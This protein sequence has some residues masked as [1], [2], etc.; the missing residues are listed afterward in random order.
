MKLTKTILDSLV[1]D[2][3]KPRFVWDSEVPGFGVR[4][5]PTGKKSFVIGYRRNKTFHTITIGKYGVL[6]LHQGREAAKD[7]L[8]KIQ[9]GGDPL[10]ERQR[11]KNTTMAMLCDEYLSRHAHKKKSHRDDF[12]R[13]RSKIRPLFGKMLIED[14]TRADIIRLHDSLSSTPYE[15][16][17]TLSLLSKMFNLAIMWE[18]VDETE[19]AFRNPCQGVRKHKETPRT[20][21]VTEDEMPRLL[22]AVQQHPSIYFQ[23]AIWLYLFTGF[24]VGEVL[25][26]KWDMIDLKNRRIHIPDTKAGRPFTIHISEPCY[27]LIKSIPKCVGNPYVLPGRRHGKPLTDIKLPWKMV[28]IKSG[29]EDVQTRDLRRTFGSW[30]VQQGATLPLLGALLNHSNTSTTKIYARFSA[31]PGINEIETH[32][33]KVASFASSGT[34]L[35]FRRMK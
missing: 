22:A 27:D 31:C 10:L 2:K 23:A 11:R 20:R 5:Y 12:S 16:N 8:A 26:L 6:T 24:R 35:Q 4:L 25:K 7:K 30:I 28:R 14:V 1:F 9:L 34:V 18:L 21:F 15:A 19:R 13:V 29:L 3:S 17:R 32:S 33:Q